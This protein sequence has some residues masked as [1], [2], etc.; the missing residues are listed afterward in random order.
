M[1]CPPW[2]QTSIARGP[3]V[4]CSDRRM[5][6][7]GQGRP[8]QAEPLAVS[9]DRAQGLRRRLCAE[10]ATVP[11]GVVQE[12]DGSTGEIGGHL[13]ANGAR[14]DFLPI[15]TPCGPVDDLE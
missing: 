6:R 5:C 14:A 3:A 11:C 12:D 4:P 15:E 7:V 9:H 13:A 2:Q 8:R 10:P 1:K